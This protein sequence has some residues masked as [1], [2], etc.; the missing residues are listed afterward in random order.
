MPF[1]SCGTYRHTLLKRQIEKR[2]DEILDNIYVFCSIK[3][4]MC[5]YQVEILEKYDQ[6]EYILAQIEETNKKPRAGT[7]PLVAVP[8]RL[9]LTETELNSILQ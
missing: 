9:E 7:S 4:C 1:T 3:N 5:R 2:D 6:L 8:L